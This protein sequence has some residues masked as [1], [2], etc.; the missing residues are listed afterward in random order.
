MERNHTV[1]R[2][3]GM[4]YTL[5]GEFSEEYM[6]RV[7]IFV[8]K[9]MEAIT[10]ANPKLSTTM[11]AV[12]VS[13]NIADELIRLKDNLAEEVREV[14]SPAPSAAG[15]MEAEYKAPRPSARL[16]QKPRTKT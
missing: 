14:P 8:D 5:A 1:V 16:Q 2:I 13:L 3:G 4:D 7:A 12:L 6:H 15:G 10:Q 11:A 9:K